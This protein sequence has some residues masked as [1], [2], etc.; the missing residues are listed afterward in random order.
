[1]KQGKNITRLGFWDELQKIGFSPVQFTFQGLWISTGCALPFKG[2][3]I[4]IEPNT[5]GEYVLTFYCG[6]IRL[7]KYITA[8]QIMNEVRE[9]MK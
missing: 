3:E 6:D 1:M 5:R 8:R 9:I 7:H 4:L 2:S